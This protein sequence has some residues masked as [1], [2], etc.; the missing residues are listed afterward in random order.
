MPCRTDYD[1]PPVRVVT[2]YKDDPKMIELICSACRA[3]QR[4]G[5]DFDENP[6]LSVW[7][8][9]H[10]IQDAE[11]QERE[12]QK[13]AKAEYERRIVEEALAKK[14]TELTEDEKKLLRKHKYL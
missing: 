10:K 4:M 1:S 5:Y 13:A 11:R 12:R 14:I 6:A 2:Q 9:S 8:E 3:L 7:W